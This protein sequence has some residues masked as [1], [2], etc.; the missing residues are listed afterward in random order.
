MDMDIEVES[1]PV[2]ISQ[3]D[4]EQ[5]VDDEN[6]DPTVQDDSDTAGRNDADNGDDESA[7]A[8]RRQRRRK[9]G[10]DIASST[11]KDQSTSAEVI[12]T[13]EL[14]AG[15]GASV[16]DASTVA[17]HI[18]AASKLPTLNDVQEEALRKAKRYAVEQ[19]VQSLLTKQAT[20]QQQQVSALQ[21][22]AQQQ[23]ALALMCRIY[24][25][26]I[27]FDLREDHIKQTF[28]PFGPIKNIN[29]SWDTVTMKHKGFAFIEFETPEAAQLALEQMNGQLM[30][31]RN[32][33]VGRPTQMPQAGPLIQQIEEEAKNYARI[34]V[35]SVHPD[36]SESD[37]KSVFEAFGKIKSCTMPL[38]NITGKHR[39]YCYIELDGLQSAMDAIA[40]MNMFDLGGQYL[41]VGRAVTPPTAT[42]QP[43]TLPPAAALAAAAVSAKIQSQDTG[44]SIP[45]ATLAAN[46]L[47]A[48]NLVGV[49]SI[50]SVTTVLPTVPTGVVAVTPTT[51]VLTSVATVPTTSI[52]TVT[53]TLAAAA[54]P[55]PPP[56]PPTTTV[57][58]EAEPQSTP[59]E[60]VAA[61]LANA[62]KLSE[63]NAINQPEMQS[64]SHEES[65]SISGST[66]R[67]M[68]MQKLSRKEEQSQ[69]IILKNMVSV[70]DID[71]DLE[72]EVTEE[73]SKYGTVKRVIIYQ[74][75]QGEEDNADVL[76]KIFVEFDSPSQAGNAIDALNGRW[77][78]GRTI[79]AETYDVTKYSTGDLSA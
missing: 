6:R 62:K 40:S 18:L 49:T 29:L 63:E 12:Q 30:G 68:V 10:W 9:R 45:T 50:N 16:H 64:L 33:K 77:F 11:D 67:Y 56:P 24:V 78:G 46:P 3:N 27:S 38:D 51:T 25:G 22:A 66:A 20:V 8:N 65:M 42:A 73:C 31:G 54:A 41:R 21:V 74:E 14:L 34:Y 59:A 19:S 2:K 15:P 61:V 28:S 57:V 60:K 26:S 53:E 69:V 79:K 17:K 76:V 1:D 35:A 48:T 44:I 58:A 75:R 13:G 5:S 55:P 23:R 7:Q 71:E 32:I 37:I 4:Q 52:V 70:E 72:T 39:G 43:N 47:I 36:L